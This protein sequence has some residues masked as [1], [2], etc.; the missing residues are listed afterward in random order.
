MQEPVGSDFSSGA[1]LATAGDVQNGSVATQA[2]GS[3]RPS[4][5]DGH[6]E[7]NSSLADNNVEKAEELSSGMITEV[8]FF[9][10]I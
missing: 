10:S 5:N 9:F 7:G 1:T 8:I 3:E 4:N 6:V 2:G